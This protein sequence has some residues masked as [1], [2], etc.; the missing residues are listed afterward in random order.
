VLTVVGRGADLAGARATAERAAD[1]I[2]WDGVQRRHD[3]AADLP[4][5][6]VTV[7]SPA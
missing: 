4:A 7:G 2:S 3:I 1:A 6:P 5:T